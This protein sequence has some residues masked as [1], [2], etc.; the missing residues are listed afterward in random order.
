GGAAEE[1]VAA[2]AGVSGESLEAVLRS[3]V[4]KS[5]VQRSAEGVRRYTV[6]ALLRAYGLEQAQERGDWEALQRRHAAV[7]V[8]LAEDTNQQLEGRD[9]MA[10]LA[11][12]EGEQDNLYAA[13]HSLQAHGELDA[14]LYLSG[15][16]WLFWYLRGHV[17]EGR[18][19]LDRLLVSAAHQEAE[20]APPT[21]ARALLGAGT[22][23]YAQGD[24][25][26]A[27]RLLSRSL[28]IQREI[29]YRAGIGACLNNLALIAETRGDYVRARALHEANI[30]VGR[31]DQHAH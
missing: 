23:A 12:L 11:R 27:E 10:T 9:Q 18:E 26:N 24:L 29:A 8:K 28:V 3:L 22:L 20:I 7:Y 31:D 21:R 16:L 14:A 1:L 13:L 25:E 30:A 2:V 6:L 15:K 5:L 17:R 4:D 19:W